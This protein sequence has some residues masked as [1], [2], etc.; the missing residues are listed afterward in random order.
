MCAVGVRDIAIGSQTLHILSFAQRQRKHPERPASYNTIWTLCLDP[1][2][3]LI[4]GSDHNFSNNIYNMASKS[5]SQVDDSPIDSRLSDSIMSPQIQNAS[6]EGGSLKSAHK[7]IDLRLILWYSFVY[8]IMR[9]HVSNISNTAIINLEQ[10]DGIKEQLGNLSSG[11]WA[12]VF[13]IFYYPYMFLE[14]FATLALKKFTP[15][16]WMARIMV[17]WVCIRFRS[18]WSRG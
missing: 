16:V 18:G 14:P 4:H 12:W 9:I 1:E 17:T 15:R 7:K 10:G 11:Q 6:K 13:S 8:L 3:T 2:T 5:T